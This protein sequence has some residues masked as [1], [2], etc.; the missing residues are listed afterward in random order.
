MAPGPGARQAHS[1]Q[2]ELPSSHPIPPNS[3]TEV[4]ARNKSCR[5]LTSQ[6]TRRLPH[7]HVLPRPCDVRRKTTTCI[8]SIPRSGICREIAI[9]TIMTSCS[10]AGLLMRQRSGLK[11][12][13]RGQHGLPFRGQSKNMFRRPCC[14]VGPKRRLWC[15]SRAHLEQN[16]RGVGARQLH[17]STEEI[18]EKPLCLNERGV[19]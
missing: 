6:G 17:K 4:N 8:T 15:S 9:H 19:V 13:L 18:L 3:C 10:G 16:G 12:S 2:P 14:R 1:L 11:S 7:T 5:V